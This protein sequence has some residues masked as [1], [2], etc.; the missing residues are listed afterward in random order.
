MLPWV[1]HPQWRGRTTSGSIDT[2]TLLPDAGKDRYLDP[3][4]PLD[5]PYPG[6][7]GKHPISYVGK[8]QDLFCIKIH[9][10]YTPRT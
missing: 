7:D 6:D 9:F 10:F 8:M 3:S 2:V 1:P 5:A 4:P